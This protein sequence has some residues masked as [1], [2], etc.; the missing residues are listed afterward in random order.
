MS[1]TLPALPLEAW[2]P[3]KNTLHLWT[4][5]VGKIQLA[6]TAPVNHWWNATFRVDEHG[7]R[8]GRME[9]DGVALTISFD[10]V[11]HRLLVRTAK[12]EH[13]LPLRDGLSVARF[14]NDLFALLRGLGFEAGIKGVPYGVPMTTPFAQDT[15]HAS[16][17]RARV[18]DFRRA[19]EWVADVFWEFRGWFDGKAGPVQL[20]WH[21]FDLAT[22]RFSGRRAPQMRDAGAVAREA[23]R[24]E[25]ISFGWWPGDPAMP[26]PAFY[27][28]IHP[29]PESL[30]GRIL[31]P[32]AARWVPMDPDGNIHQARLDWD[33]VRTSADPRGTL[34]EFL[35]SAYA[36]AAVTASWP[37]E[38]LRSS[39]CPERGRI[40]PA[41]AV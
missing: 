8:T 14:H 32:D 35:Q 23:Y 15:E 31:R 3:T 25:I 12:A 21:S 30:T 4:Q 13:E 37:H 29:E 33:V 28:Y 5:I 10:L 27:S 22:A 7:Y 36:A 2:E 20:F 6:S 9:R 26:S 40:H 11:G 17:D 1:D 39:W 19:L 24:D 41:R 16:Y 18:E 38:R 34:L